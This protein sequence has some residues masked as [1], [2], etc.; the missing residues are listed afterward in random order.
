M[1]LFRHPQPTSPSKRQLRPQ[2]ARAPGFLFARRPVRM[3][4]IDSARTLPGASSATGH[5]SAS[6]GAP[7]PCAG[8]PDPCAGAPPRLYS[9]CVCGQAMGKKSTNKK[10]ISK[11]NETSQINEIN[12][13]NKYPRVYGQAMGK[14]LCSMCGFDAPYTCRITGLRLCR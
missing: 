13:T 7:D 4:Q 11:I 6:A 9:V 3:V 10:I 5:E 1:Q 8:A 14:N 12:T 2:P